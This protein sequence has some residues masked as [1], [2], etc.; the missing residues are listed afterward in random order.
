[1]TRLAGS[2]RL[3]RS[4]NETAVLA[5]LFDRGQLTRGDLRELTGLSKPTASEVL[6]RLEEAGL[7]IVVGHESG[8]GPGPNAAIYSA[9]PEVAYTAAI[10]IRDTGE[11]VERPALAAAVANLAGDIRAR[12]E[13]PV[14]FSDVDPAEA[15]A[16][17]VAELCRKGRVPRRRLLHIVVGVPG[18]PDEATE[19]IQ[20][21]DVP[22]L[23]R[24]HLLAQIR[25]RLRTDVAFDNDV[26]LA[27]IAER[28]HGVATDVDAFAMLWLGA[29]GVGFATDLDGTLLRGAHGGA[30]EI[31]YLPVPPTG[32]N[33]IDYQDLVGGIAILDLARSFGL[34]EPTPHEAVAAAVAAGVDE[35]LTALGERIAV[36]LVSAIVL[37]DP[38]LIVLAGEVGQAGGGR[39]RDAVAEALRT[40]S[41]LG[42]KIE[43][44]GLTD[45]AVLLGGLRSGLSA[46]RERVL[47]SLAVPTAATS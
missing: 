9:N 39:L 38:P 23:S 42:T 10:S 37:L 30:G 27:A 2:S 35:F 4:M 25:E 19:T 31:G 43:C 7:A 26:N 1:M 44:T 32:T 29:E 15:L 45:D 11:A 20:Y 28:A 22:G 3:L 12:I 33:A 24:P 16:D 5:H 46:V 17:A 8:G 36:G 13:V 41:P 18:S 21:V 40:R 14:A 6:R 34:A 47:S